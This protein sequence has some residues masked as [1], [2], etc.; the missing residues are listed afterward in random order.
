[1][2][3]LIGTRRALLGSRTL[4]LLDRIPGGLAAYSLRKLRAGYTDGAIRVRRSSDST[5]QD[6][7][8][9]AAGNLDTSSLLAFTGAGDGFITTWY[10]QTGGGATFAQATTANQ[11]RIVAS[12][13]VDVINGKPTALF[14]GINDSLTGNATCN[15]L[16]KN[17][18]GM[19]LL[20]ANNFLSFLVS[21][22][23]IISFSLPA[24]A[25][26]IRLSVTALVDV[27]STANRGFNARA[28]DTDGL[29]SRNTA[30]KYDGSFA[31]NCYTIDY[32]T[33]AGVNRRNGVVID[34]GTFGSMTAGSTSNTDSLASNIG[35]F[36]GGQFPNMNLGDLILFSRVLSAAEMSLAE[37]NMAAYYGVT[38]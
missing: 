24:A 14:D 31:L 32:T 3:Y 1:M 8:F 26:S 23:C 37:S 2:P 25:S 5:E 20:A 12:G 6:I 11:P 13:V 9:D 28:L 35:S 16:L 19:S 7:G 4:P 33:A 34:S 27:G 15:A 21:N 30:S 29:S 36:N 17:K 22:R 38:I 10:D 18:T